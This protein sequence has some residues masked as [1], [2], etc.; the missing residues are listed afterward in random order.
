MNELIK[1]HANLEGANLEGANLKG[2]NLKGANLQEANLQGANLRWAIGNNR[3][4]K[5]LHL[6][7]YITCISCGAIAI[8]CKQYTPNEWWG[9]ADV[10]I[11]VMDEGALKW[12]NEW[13]DT[14]KKVWEAM[15]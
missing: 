12:W 6:G 13:K 2:A 11:A 7:T 10:D 1:Q 15:A 9:F 3:E 4:L 5:T 14:I 8:G